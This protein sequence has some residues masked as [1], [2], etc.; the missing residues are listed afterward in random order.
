M[1]TRSKIF[2]GTAN[3]RLAAEIADR[4]DVKLGACAIDR[5][6]DGEVAVHLLVAT[7]VERVLADA[8][9]RAGIP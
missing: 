3:T 2:A 7:A 5:L 8:A 1:T 6:P 9:P 4:L